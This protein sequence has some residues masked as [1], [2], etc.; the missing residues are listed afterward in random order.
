MTWTPK[1]GDRV[2]KNPERWRASECDVY[3]DGVGKV[4]KP[5]FA[6]VDGVFGDPPSVDVQWA[7]GRYFHYCYELLPY[8]EDE[9]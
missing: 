9:K 4:I 6:H 1:I 2:V 5:P 7:D 8:Q 3:I